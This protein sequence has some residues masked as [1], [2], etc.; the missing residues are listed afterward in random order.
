MF[1]AHTRRTFSPKPFGVAIALALAASGCASDY[2]NPSTGIT[3]YQPS[4][5]N[6]SGPARTGQATVPTGGGNQLPQRAG[7]ARYPGSA[8]P[9]N[10]SESAPARTGSASTPTGGPGQ[11]AP[12]P[13]T[14]AMNRLPRT[15]SSVNESAPAR[16]GSASVPTAQVPAFETADVNRN[17]VIDRFEYE[18]LFQGR[19]ATR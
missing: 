2:N 12:T 10:V 6:E 5:V 3:R 16:T 7:S 13:T 9:S 14:E 4:T 17:G 1:N 19:G 11:S 15:P 18:G 8:I